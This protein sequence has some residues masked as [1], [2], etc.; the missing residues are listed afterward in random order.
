MEEMRRV[1]EKAPRRS[2]W[3]HPRRMLFGSTLVAACVVLG[4]A[5]TSSAAAPARGVPRSA[6]PRSPAP[7][8]WTA[9]SNNAAQPSSSPTVV[10]TDKAANA[11]VLWYREI[12]TSSTFTYEAAVVGPDGSLVT[13]PYSIFGSS[14]WLGL[15][16]KPALVAHGN[17]PLVVFDG[18]RSFSSTDPYSHGCIVGALASKPDWTPQAWSLSNDC[19]NPT[20]GGATETKTGELSA[21][22]P[23]GEGVEYRLGTSGTIPATGTDGQ[24]PVASANVGEVGEAADTAGNDDVY[25]GWEQIFSHPASADGYYVQD[26]TSDGPVRRAPDSG[27]NSTNF[28]NLY[29]DLPI[30]STNTHSGVFLAYCSNASSS[31]CSLLLWRVGSAKALKIPRSAGAY[32]VAISAGP[33]GRLWIAWYNQSTDTISTVRTNRSDTAFGP[34]EVYRTPFCFEHGLVGVSGGSW[35]RLDVALQCVNQSLRNEEYVTQSLTA[36]AVSP[37]RATIHNTVSHNVTFTV[38]D[39]GDRVAGAKVRV[40]GMSAT[41]G[42]SGTATFSFPKGMATGDYLV[43]AKALNYFSAHG[44]LHVKG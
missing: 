41:T 40:A 33:D 38:T 44:T 19:Y 35:G 4:A 9:L 14:G 43:V 8:K 32:H 36:L 20:N 25:V 3:S 42:P 28:L 2:R 27:T 17:T 37:D 13:H 39:A 15:S 24:I 21:A 12:G 18:T 22:W 5:G 34:V 16:D 6:L 31:T 30:T 26:V 10:W 29:S 23:G 11:T 7:G 1:A